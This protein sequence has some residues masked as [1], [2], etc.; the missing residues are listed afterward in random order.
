[1]YKIENRILEKIIK[2]KWQRLIKDLKPEINAMADFQISSELESNPDKKGYYGGKNTTRRIKCNACKINKQI[3]SLISLYPKV[4]RL[5][6]EERIINIL[7]HEIIHLFT[8]NEPAADSLI[9]FTDF[10]KKNAQW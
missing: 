2:N 7:C 9:K 3:K 6:L 8:N 10:F 4:L 1:M 5:E